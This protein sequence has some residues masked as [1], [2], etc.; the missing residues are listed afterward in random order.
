MVSV[1]VKGASDALDV[2]LGLIIPWRREHAERRAKLENA[3]RHSEIQR[4]NAETLIAQA[5]AEREKAAKEL[6]NKQTE[7]AIAQAKK[8]EAEAALIFA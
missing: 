4:L 3:Q 8:L 7:L 2:L 5:K 6:D 1:D